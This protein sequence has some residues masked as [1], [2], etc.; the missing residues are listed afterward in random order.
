MAKYFV[1]AKIAEVAEFVRGARARAN[2]RDVIGP[3]I[4]AGQI[5]E[6]A[7]VGKVAITYTTNDPTIT[8]DEAITI[9]D[10]AAPSNDELLEFCEEL[11]DQ[12][13]LVVA[14]LDAAGVTA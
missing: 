13:A 6:Q 11:N 8:T 1:T 2:F 9:A 14:A 10:G 7:T 4:A 5:D 12:M 3:E